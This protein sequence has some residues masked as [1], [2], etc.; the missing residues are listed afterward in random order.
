MSAA[1]AEPKTAVKVPLLDLK[2]QYQSIEQDVRKVI[3]EVL[4]SQRFILGPNV[5]ELEKEIAA[6]SQCGFGIGVS[7]GTDALLLALMALDVGHGDEVITTGSYGLNH[8]GGASGMSL[9]EVLDAAHGHE[10]NEDGSEM[11]AE[12]KAAHEE[13]RVASAG[14]AHGAARSASVGRAQRDAAADVVACAAA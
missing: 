10:H 8:V 5:T 11:T 9:K 3:D 12:Q 14:E 4:V 7:S 13:D 2:A 1:T 6:Y